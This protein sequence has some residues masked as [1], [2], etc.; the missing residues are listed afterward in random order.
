MAKNI[1]T[2]A[3]DI[4]DVL[5]C[6]PLS[7]ESA[8]EAGIDAGMMAGARVKRALSKV[9]R[10]N[11][12][13]FTIYP[14]EV[15]HPCMRKLW[16]DRHFDAATM[17]P[18]ETIGPQTKFKFMYG[19]M[20]ECL[21]VPLIKATGWKVTGVDEKLQRTFRD[22]SNDTWTVSGRTDICIDGHVMD[23]KSMSG[24]SYQMYTSKGIPGADTFGY[25]WQ[26]HT[27][28][29]MAGQETPSALLGINKENG[30]L[31]VIENEDTSLIDTE[32]KLM[33]IAH[34]VKDALILPAGMMPMPEG[35][36]GNLKLGTVCS[37]CKYKAECWKSANGFTGPRK[38]LY[39]GN[40]VTY[41]VEVKREP[42]VS[43]IT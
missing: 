1:A 34:G 3:N 22:A 18:V 21:A 42:K 14:S 24:I 13:A 37:Y 9:D 10:G 33:S 35:A 43:E 27:Y 39:A 23:I 8:A 6:L 15:G 28:N 38:F 20:L 17:K 11:T 32:S 19:D 2:L 7:K 41:L 4:K 12:P 29:W 36:S 30:D 26:L 31:A 5:R 16:Y 25:R 40:R